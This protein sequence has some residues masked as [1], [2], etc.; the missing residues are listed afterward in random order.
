MTLPV[1]PFGRDVIE[2]V[3]YFDSVRVGAD[4]EFLTRVRL[5]FGAGAINSLEEP[6]GVGLHHG[7]SLTQDGE[8]GFDENRYSPVRSAYA[9]KAL[10]WQI[11][12]VLGGETLAVPVRVDERHFEV[13]PSMNPF[14]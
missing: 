7:R 8:N 9:E 11:E 5:T 1:A 2:R 6:L 10:D 13:P 4:A 12:R 14:L 3:G